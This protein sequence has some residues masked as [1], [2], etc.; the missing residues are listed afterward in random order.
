MDAV[1]E[2]SATSDREIR[3]ESDFTNEHCEG[4]LQEE[5]NIKWKPGRLERRIGKA[6]FE[7]QLCLNC[8]MLPICMGPCSQKQIEAGADGLSGVCMLNALEMQLDE[9]IEFT[10]NN[11]AN[12]NK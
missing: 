12:A 5:G 6:T 3:F 9:Y 10:F 7:N 8:K 1:S 2:L 4:I 11:M